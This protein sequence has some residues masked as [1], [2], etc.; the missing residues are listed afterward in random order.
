MLHLLVRHDDLNRP[1]HLGRFPI[2]SHLYKHSKHLFF[3]VR[4]LIQTSIF[5]HVTSWSTMIAE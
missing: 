5:L 3:L 2:G 4:F 1:I